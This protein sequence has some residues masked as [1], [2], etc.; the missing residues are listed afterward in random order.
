MG[1]L[2]ADL[3]QV[4]ETTRDDLSLTPNLADMALGETAYILRGVA[5]GIRCK[6]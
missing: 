5:E 1:H 6:L 3:V 4:L 2:C